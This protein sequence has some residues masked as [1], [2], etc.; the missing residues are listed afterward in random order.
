MY[1][2]VITGG[3][4]F[5]PEGRIAADVAVEGAQIVAVGPDLAG[6]AREVVVA[7]GRWV[8]PGAVD[9]HVHLGLP[10]EGGAVSDGFKNGSRAAAA[11]GVTTIIDYTTPSPGQG[12]LD[13]IAARRALA[14]GEVV[15]DYGLHAV[16]IDWN[17]RLARELPAA[18]DA[19]VTSVKLFMIYRDRDWMADDARLRS[20]MEAAADLG[21]V[22]CV[23]A[24]DDATIEVAVARARASGEL[25]I[26]AFAASRS[27]SQEAHAVERVC[28]IAADTG[29]HLHLVHLSAAASVDALARAKDAGVKVT[30]ETCPQYLLLDESLYLKPHGHRFASCPPLRTRTDR[31]RLW[32][33]VA[34]GT[35]DLIATDS[36]GFDASA[37]DS[38][39]GDFTRIPYGLPGVETMLPLVLDEGRRRGI[40][41]ARLVCAMSAAPARRFGLSPR[42]GR[43]S[44]GA[45]A[46]LVVYD[47]DAPWIV[48]HGSLV[49]GL[50]YSPYEGRIVQGRPVAV[51][52]RGQ[53][54]A[55]RGA[56]EYAAGRGRFVP[57]EPTC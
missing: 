39:G 54:V 38:W 28:G 50:G 30:G 53:R 13:A 44:P 51:W 34:D 47:P 10:L 56:P 2:L 48:D 52:R 5:R 1:D 19:G 29:A 20:V 49:T 45:D 24:E 14:D 18:V 7:E 31:S 33:A 9:A 22:V 11:G 42:K 23:H 46:D 41:P 43:L 27:A 25:G 4:V 36:C 26:A 6:R 21:V 3:E 17:D 16:L 57:R 8:L 32:R 37:K 15:T 12:L 55:T 40:H 35:I